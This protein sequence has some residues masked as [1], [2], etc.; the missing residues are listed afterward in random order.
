MMTTH[1][2]GATALTNALLGDASV[3]QRRGKDRLPRRRV[4]AIFGG[5]AT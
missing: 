4:G 3:S 2:I 5:A 1:L